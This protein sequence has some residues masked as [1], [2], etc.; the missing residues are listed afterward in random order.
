MSGGFT[1]RPATRADA[2][3]IAA[4]YAHH[5][6]YGTATFETVPPGAAEMTARVAEGLDAGWPWLVADESD[7]AIAGYAYAAQFRPRAAFRHA[8]EDSIY[9][10]HDR[11]GQG[12]GTALL[13]ALIEAA[14]VSGFRQMIAGITGGETASIAMHARAGF[15]E[16]GRLAG[17][18][19]KGGRWLDL[20]YMQRA[21][22][23]GDEEAPA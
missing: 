21:L 14:Q 8:C 15:R 6:L 19:H 18:G 20:V 17:V 9:L 10:R 5:V 16:V 4:I 22:G 23:A 11:L 1:I 3:A 2:A 12:I 13:A 7:G